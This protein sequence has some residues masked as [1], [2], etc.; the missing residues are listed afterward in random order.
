MFSMPTTC[1]FGVVMSA[2]AEYSKTPACESATDIDVRVNGAPVSISDMFD[3]N[4]KSPLGLA[5]PMTLS[6][7][8]VAAL[9]NPMIASASASR[10]GVVRMKAL[11]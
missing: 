6:S 4:M 3:S 10:K 11:L 9:L 2:S 1:N 5:R 8:A 7:A